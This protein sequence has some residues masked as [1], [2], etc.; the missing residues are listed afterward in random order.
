MGDSPAVGGLLLTINTGSSSVKIAGY[1]NEP[2]LPPLFRLAVD[3]I[4]QP[5]TV[6]HVTE[7]RENA[8]E[9]RPIPWEGH[10]NAI[11]SALEYAHRTFAFRTDAVG[12]RVVH[13]GA[14][15]AA[16][17]RV[18]ASLLA[19]LRRLAVLDPSHMPRALEAIDATTQQYPEVPQVACFDTAFHRTMPELAQRYPLPSWTRTAG[20]CRYGFHG[21]SCEFILSA[22]AQLDPPAQRGRVLIAHLGNGASV[23]AMHD[24]AS[25]DTTMGFS[26]TGGLMMGTR[27]GDLDPTVLTYLARTQHRDIETLEHVVDDESGLLGVSGISSDV[28]DLLRQPVSASAVEAIEL[29]CYIARKHIGALAAVLDG[30]DT[31]VFTGGIGEHAPSIRERICTGLGHLGVQ[32]D[33]THNAA[34]HD[35]IST[36]GSMVVV[37]VIA[38]NEELMIARHVR[39]VLA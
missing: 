14:A 12:H 13:G 32:L 34:N 26:P 19:D 10:G 29:F 6:V 8:F 9:N 25:V 16:P 15:H 7:P 4:G 2:T 28:R 36:P 38:T 33:R 22:L 20:V 18:T 39:A 17:E 27:S 21:L 31:L 24:G 5:G 3:R 30:I 37:R 1:R 23:T 11:L 35:V